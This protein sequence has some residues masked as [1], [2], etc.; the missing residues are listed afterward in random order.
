MNKRRI[1]NLFYLSATVI[2]LAV[3]V[4]LVSRWYSLILKDA[5]LSHQKQQLEMSKTSATGIQIFFDHLSSQM[6][7]GN[8]AAAILENDREKDY[9]LNVFFNHFMSE[10][11]DGIYLLDNEKLK[12]IRGNNLTEQEIKDIT[13]FRLNEIFITDIFIDDIT[14]SQ[15]YFFF[16]KKLTPELRDSKIFFLKI[17][18]D[19]VMKRYLF[20]LQ[21]TKSDFA[22]VLDD[23][24][25]LVYH[26]NHED[27]LLYNIF[28]STEDCGNC[29]ESFDVQKNMLLT[30]SGFG[31]YNIGD[32]PPKIMA[33]S[34][35]R[36]A[37]R[38]WLLAISTFLPDV[39]SELQSKLSLLIFSSSL[40]FLIIFGFTFFNYR[41]NLKRIKAE[42][43]KKSALQEVKYQ[44]ELNHVSKLASLGELVDTVAHEINTPI[45]IISVQADSLKHKISTDPVSEEL[46]VIKKQ[47]NRISDYTRSLLNYSKRLP[48]KPKYENIT[49]VIDDSIY[50]LGH[51]FREK[52]IKLVKK[53]QSPLPELLIDRLQI[54]QVLINI[55][56]NASDSMNVS[57]E[58][59]VN[60]EE[61]SE[62]Q[63]SEEFSE[64]I[65]IRIRNTGDKIPEQLISQIF[66][67]FFTTKAEGKGT[68][69]GLSISKKIIQRHGGSIEVINNETGPEF[70]IRLPLKQNR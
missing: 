4:L 66:E 61:Y 3:F 1:F 58:I 12:V 37:N 11:V 54:E 49:S 25:T 45:S 67:P 50:L 52:K 5:K 35:I 17:N 8:Y 70:I 60:V 14:N 16:C 63:N 31:E 10:G 21:L 26:P 22:W 69:L 40:I 41:A 24:G 48:Y 2:A 59:G 29:H 6:S 13:K 19:F 36:I 34:P 28:E 62:D 68:G 7:L 9:T 33:Y 20:P 56:N 42:E 65:I 18:L 43:E 57:G 15:K 47:I 23:E 51:R 46:Q 44:D 27:M 30:K 53:Y 55:F 38:Q 39:I 32:E 64:G